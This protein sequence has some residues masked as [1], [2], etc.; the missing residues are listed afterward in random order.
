MGAAFWAIGMAAAAGVRPVPG[1]ARAA[2]AGLLV[3]TLAAFLAANLGRQRAW[4][5]AA[6]LR[7]R[8][9][10]NI[11]PIVRAEGC[12]RISARSVPD[13]LRGVYVFRNGFAEALEQAAGPRTATGRDCSGN[14]D[15]ER[16]TLDR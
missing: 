16:L 7:D 6:E 13:S 4:S 1:F 5:D 10:A 3:V 11:A 12:D 9:L 14:W 15:G 2:A 8:V